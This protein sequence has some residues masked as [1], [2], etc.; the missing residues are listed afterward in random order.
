MILSIFFITNN[1]NLRDKIKI[2]NKFKE[3]FYQLKYKKQFRAILW[4][5]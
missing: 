3:L 1:I 4:E 2:T 5:R